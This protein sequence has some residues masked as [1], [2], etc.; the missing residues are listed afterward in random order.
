MDKYML[1]VSEPY[2][3]KGDLI[4]VNEIFE[5][6]LVGD[7]EYIYA[8]PK[9]S[10]PEGDESNMTQE[11][12]EDNENLFDK[13]W[14]FG[15]VVSL[16]MF[17]KYTLLQKD[18]TVIDSN[19][20]ETVEAYEYFRNSNLTVVVNDENIEAYDIWPVATYDLDTLDANNNFNFEGAM[21]HH[22][23]L[24]K[25]DESNEFPYLIRFWCNWSGEELDKGEL[26]SADELMDRFEEY[27]DWAEI[28]KWAGID[29][30]EN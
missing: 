27:E 23:E 26:M 18:A 6:V 7:G 25:L 15:D 21:G 11:W 22:A 20:V 2:T 8:L 5:G 9:G 17:D 29:Y 24:W 1:W 28:A 13:V 10:T 12:L 3:G 16:D 4:P 30:L 14:T 19:M